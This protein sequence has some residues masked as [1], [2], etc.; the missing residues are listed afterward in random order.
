MI[1]AAPG[2]ISM[3][4]NMTHPQSLSLQLQQPQQ[5]QATQQFVTMLPQQS[6][7]MPGTFHLGAN[8]IIQQQPVSQ[9]TFQIIGAPNSNPLIGPTS[10]IL[11]Q[12]QLITN[13]NGQ[14]TL[15]TNQSGQHQLIT[16]QNGQ[17][18]LIT[19][20]QNGTPQLITNQNGQTQLLITSPQQFQ[21]QPQPSQ[22]NSVPVQQQIV[23]FVLPNGQIVQTIQPQQ[24]NMMAQ[25]TIQ[26]QPQLTVPLQANGQGPAT[27]TILTQNMS[28]PG[29][30]F[31]NSSQTSTL[32]ANII[33]HTSNP[34]P[35]M[36][37]NIAQQSQTP[38]ITGQVLLHSPTIQ[39][40]TVVL[41]NNNN[42]SSTP[43]LLIPSSMS[44]PNQQQ[45]SGSSVNSA[46]MVV[47]TPSMATSSIP[48]G[49]TVTTAT[50]NSSMSSAKVEQ[51]GSKKIPPQI[52]ASIAQKIMGT[53]VKQ[54]QPVV[55]S[56]LSTFSSSTQI[57]GVTMSEKTTSPL[58]M[59]DS[60]TSSFSS[61]SA[62][63]P[64]STEN[65]ENRFSPV[66]NNEIATQTSIEYKEEEGMDGEISRPSRPAST[67]SSG[68]LRIAETEDVMND[69]DYDDSDTD[70]D[71]TEIN[72]EQ[73]IVDNAEGEDSNQTPDNNQVT[74][75]NDPITQSQTAAQGN[76][77]S[78]FIPN[79]T[80]TEDEEEEEIEQASDTNNET[81]AIKLVRKNGLTKAAYDLINNRILNSD[82]ENVN[83]SESRGSPFCEEVSSFNEK[84]NEATSTT[85]LTHNSTFSSPASMLSEGGEMN[86]Q[87][88]LVPSS[89]CKCL[90]SFFRVFLNSLS[91]L[92]LISA[93]I[94]NND[95]SESPI[96]DGV[97]LKE[98]QDFAKA[99]KL[100][101]IGLN[102]TQSQV[103]NELNQNN[104]PCYSQSAICR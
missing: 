98:I 10:A 9:P 91:L 89:R 86:T 61:S 24:Q 73:T 1:S 70:S 71:T 74:S 60:K 5:Q 87:N 97:N 2:T 15:I 13:Q 90:I 33:G 63:S 62:S 41:R 56:Q 68:S 47:L 55:T 28:L 20:N 7:S 85:Q 58:M 40:N 21:Q 50:V 49:G 80:D 79:F 67:S 82:D 37:E 100:C 65:N 19:T 25:Q 35:T 43:T 88:D 31:I 27:A 39:P 16:N 101:R 66:N 102:L 95:S 103:G 57:T 18:Q 23:Q 17:P 34:V 84:S 77:Q 94:A 22:A 52:P 81:G 69:E 11:S 36:F 64:Q 42:T 45:H 14:P 44:G 93:L 6:Q 3:M 29:Q 46:T 30:S 96:I 4:P 48:I 38:T 78:P 76:R 92:G 59:V 8:Q 32:Q 54:Q 72:S 12:P 26:Q 104:G 53:N 99:F 75:T 51:K 83:S